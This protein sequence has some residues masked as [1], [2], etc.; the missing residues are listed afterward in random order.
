MRQG[1][2]VSLIYMG[3]NVSNQVADV[4]L[5][6]EAEMRRVGLWQE[7]PPSDEALASTQ[8]F[9]FD[10]MEFHQ[11]LQWVLIPKTAELIEKNL[12]LPSVSDIAS[13]AEYRFEQIPEETDELLVL[14]RKYDQLLGGT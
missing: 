4:I 7:T 13:L 10:A 1:F 9:C 6:I 14:L 3:T 11:W 8:P 12:D 2:S 5:L